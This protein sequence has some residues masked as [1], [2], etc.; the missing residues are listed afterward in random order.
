MRTLALVSL[1]ALIVTPFASAAF[2][3]DI[4][5][6]G[7]TD[8]N[9]SLTAAIGDNGRGSDIVLAP[10][11]FN[12][13]S[14][15]VG[16]DPNYDGGNLVGM[17][18]SELL[19]D[20]DKQWGGTTYNNNVTAMSRALVA[21]GDAYLELAAGKWGAHDN[22]WVT[23]LVYDASAS[24]ENA[25]FAVNAGFGAWIDQSGATPNSGGQLTGKLQVA[26]D[27][28]FKIGV[29]PRF[30]ID[31]GGVTFGMMGSEDV[32]DMAVQGSTGDLFVVGRAG[33]NGQILN[34]PVSGALANATGSRLADIAGTPAV[35][36]ASAM[37][38]YTGAV[39]SQDHLLVVDRSLQNIEVF[40]IS[41]GALQLVGSYALGAE[42]SVAPED[43][44]ILDEGDGTVRVVVD[45]LDPAAVVKLA[46]LDITLANPAAASVVNL[47]QAGGLSENGA[48]STLNRV[49][50]VYVSPEGDIIAQDSRDQNDD[51]W[52]GISTDSLAAALTGDGSLQT[53]GTT[54][55]YMWTSYAGFNYARGLVFTPE[56]ASLALLVMGGLALIR[57]RK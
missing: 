24:I 49:D 10:V 9:D 12:A 53:V 44:A 38:W 54:L 39:E 18:S 27:T 55:D 15:F 46:V 40:A 16:G 19:G 32:W 56:P 29:D 34:V 13:G 23:Q 21:H 8:Y 52:A 35:A 5:F 3:G 37:T 6:A 7:A 47:L 4:I 20:S 1:L 51:R 14:E 42:L 2:S 36:H 57:R 11:N 25:L 41:S 30:T 48:G 33:M 28:G 50:G 43:L 26:S 22:V 17:G 31:A 45:V